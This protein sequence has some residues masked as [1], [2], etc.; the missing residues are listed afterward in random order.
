M[1]TARILANRSGSSIGFAKWV[2]A[3]LCVAPYC[4]I[5]VRYTTG[6]VDPARKLNFHSR[7]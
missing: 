5:C 4:L 3:S 1:R 7:L 2:V 6:A